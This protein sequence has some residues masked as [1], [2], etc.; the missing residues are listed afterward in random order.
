MKKIFFI[1][2]ILFLSFILRFYQLGKVPISLE[3]DEVAI[4]YDA[5]SIL[6]TGRDQFGKFLPLTFRSLDDWKPP[7]YEYAAV[8]SIGLFGL[9]EFGVR[10]P[11]AFFGT[12]TVL[13]TYLLVKQIFGKTKIAL[14]ASFFLAISPWHLQFS[15]ATFEVNL[16]VF[17]TVSAVTAFLAG[18]KNNRFFL[19]SALLFGLDL[20]SYH[21]TRVVTPLLLVSLF[22]IFNRQLPSRKTVLGFLAIYGLFFVMFLPILFSADA[23]IRFKA[24]NIFN[25]GAR[26]LD[27]RDLEKEYLDKR[28]EDQNAGFELAGKIFHNGRLIYTDY[29]TLKKAFGKYISHFDFEFLFVK[30]DAPLH[31]APGFGLLYIWE[32]PFLLAGIY[33]IFRHGLNRY[34]L[35]LPIWLLVAP[36]PVAVTRE[37]PHAV[38]SELILPMWQI[39]TAVGLAT[40]FAAVKDESKWVVI[41][42]TAGISILLAVNNASYLHQYYMHTNYELSDKWLYGRK[43][44]VEFTESVK[45]NYDKVLV[46]MR[47]DMPYIFWL[48][49]SKYPPA[50]YLQEG[51]TVSGGFED[52][53]NHFDKYEFR[54]FDYKNLTTDQKLLLVGLPQDFPPDAKII[55]TIYY[56]NG[57]EALKIAV[58]K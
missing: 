18:L 51:G 55:K 24:T 28:I 30:G 41:S 37:A 31:H 2:A 8:P 54:N 58:N 42:A 6:K 10:F 49:Y 17:I 44:A 7:I 22:L 23:Q 33:Y 3:W 38:R 27:E 47:V 5:Y 14:I 25:P 11:S 39:F 52:Q 50:K 29:E 57:K 46:S 26:Y 40:V 56:L 43:E 9:S 48:F 20:F 19:L 32:L 36:I 1:A 16:S 34:T 45:E 35:I 53:R 12:L 15:R 4:G 21:S 13:V